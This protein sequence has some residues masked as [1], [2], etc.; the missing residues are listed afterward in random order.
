V[1]AKIDALAFVPGVAKVADAFQSMRPSMRR[2]IV[3][4]VIEAAKER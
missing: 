1:E 2:A 4:L 3:R